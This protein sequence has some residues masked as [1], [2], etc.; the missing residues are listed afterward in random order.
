MKTTMT[1]LFL[2]ALLVSASH[3]LTPGHVPGPRPIPAYSEQWPDTYEYV[4]PTGQPTPLYIGVR[5]PSRGWPTR[6]IPRA[7]FDARIEP[8]SVLA[9]RLLRRALDRWPSPEVRRHIPSALHAAAPPAAPV[10]P[11]AWVIDF[12]LKN[13]D[14]RRDWL[15]LAIRPATRADLDRLSAVRVPGELPAV[16]PLAPAAE[17]AVSFL[18]PH[19]RAL[20]AAWEPSAE[21]GYPRVQTFVDA[22]GRPDA[23]LI[24]NVFHDDDESLWDK[25]LLRQWRFDDRAG[26]TILEGR[27]IDGSTAAGAAAA[28]RLRSRL[29]ADPAG[30]IAYEQLPRTRAGGETIVYR[31][32]VTESPS[33]LRVLGGGVSVTSS[34]AVVPTILIPGSY[35]EAPLAF[36]VSRSTLA[37]ACRLAGRLDAARYMRL[38]G[39]LDGEEIADPELAGASGVRFLDRTTRLPTTQLHRV[40][41]YLERYHRRLGF[42]PRRQRCSYKGRTF[43]NVI[44]DIPGRTDEWVLLA[45]H[46]DAAVSEETFEPGAGPVRAAPGANDNLTAT[47]ALLEAARLLSPLAR[48]QSGLG[49]AWPLRRGIRIVHLTGEEFPADCLGAR[50]YVANALAARERIHGLV[51]MDMIGY[52]G[53][54]GRL[55]DPI[56]QLNLGEHPQSARLTGAA[57]QA[58]A[59]LRTRGLVPGALRPEVRRRFDKHSYLYNTDGVIFSDA[60]YP[61][62]FIDEHINKFHNLTRRGYHDQH[63]RRMNI[64]RP[65]ATGLARI[66]LATTLV[67]AAAD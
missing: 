35:P 15:P 31:Q 7:E 49:A 59:A 24:A 38:I 60:G 3:A 46:Y 4:F 39:E 61:V 28:A 53:D 9:V 27:D 58:F 25:A 52:A 67:L 63:D 20:Q 1:C 33:G 51:L 45:D 34:G 16:Q 48:T 55:E 2:V 30:V 40:A 32:L 5:S 54:G 6:R 47:A 18:A 17:R 22:R 43:D 66:A 37:W 14:L 42:T 12:A 13:D 50:V 44:V 64:C 19:L 36:G 10:P 21:F 41:D 65:Y 57:L 29:L 8:Q 56:F 11:T 62:L 23:K 26:A